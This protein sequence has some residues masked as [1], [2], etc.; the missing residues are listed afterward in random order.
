[1]QKVWL[2]TSTHHCLGSPE[3]LSC[4]S[5]LWPYKYW[6]DLHRPPEHTNIQKN[7]LL[8]I[9]QNYS[10]T[11]NGFFGIVYIVFK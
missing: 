3:T 1:M 2:P 6:L 4:K 10:L 5:C 8:I 9:V 11:G 7:V